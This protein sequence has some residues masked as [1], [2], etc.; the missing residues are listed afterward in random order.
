VSRRPT[1]RT[2]A[3]AHHGTYPLPVIRFKALEGPRRRYR[4]CA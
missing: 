1:C 4:S 2:N 3:V